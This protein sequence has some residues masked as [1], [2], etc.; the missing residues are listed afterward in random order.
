MVKQLFFT[1]FVLLCFTAWSQNDDPPPNWEEK[2]FAIPRTGC[3]TITNTESSTAGEFDNGVGTPSVCYEFPNSCGGWIHGN[4]NRVIDF[5]AFEANGSTS[6]KIGV[7][8][9]GF[10]P[11]IDLQVGECTALPFSFTNPTAYI[12]PL[13]VKV[14]SDSFLVCKKDIGLVGDVFFDV[15]LENFRVT[16]YSNNDYQTN[17]SITCTP[18][19]VCPDYEE[20]IYKVVCPNDTITLFNPCPN[21]DLWVIWTDPFGEILGNDETLSLFPPVLTGIY[22]W[23]GPCHKGKVVVL[24]AD[25]VKISKTPIFCSNRQRL[26]LPDGIKGQWS[27]GVFGNSIIAENSGWSFVT[28]GSCQYTDS[29][30]VEVLYNDFSLSV[31][32]N[33]DADTI[34][35]TPDLKISWEAN[36]PNAKFQLY[37]DDTRIQKVYGPG[38]Y[39]IE[40]NVDACVAYDTILVLEKLFED[41]GWNIYGPNVFAP[42]TDGPNSEFRVFGPAGSKVWLEIYDRW[43]ELIFRSSEPNEGWDGTCRGQKMNPA[44]FIWLARV[45]WGWEICPYPNG[46]VTLKR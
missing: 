31:N 2:L 32:F 46:N 23:E 10:S 42:D 44:V 37:K 20:V 7:G 21:P 24:H 11:L 43:G 12:G 14:N 36:H 1:T 28:F 35:L 40:A 30:Y 18:K 5:F 13:D 3:E 27:N 26:S 15:T 4:T 6:G 29:I 33:P 45:E 16:L 19:F 22:N 25:S 34:L 38:L 39:I 8:V 17:W 9:K 41:C